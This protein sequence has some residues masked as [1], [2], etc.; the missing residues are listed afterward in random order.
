MGGERTFI[1]KVS[2]KTDDPID[3]IVADLEM[4]IG[5]CWHGFEIESVTEEHEQWR[6]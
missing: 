3:L 2:A 6:K 5:C 1:I 4:E